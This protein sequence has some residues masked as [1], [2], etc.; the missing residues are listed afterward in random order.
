MIMVTAGAECGIG[1][2]RKSSGG[3]GE[4]NRDGDGGGGE[5][6]NNGDEDGRKSM[7]R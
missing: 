1:D 2:E 7:W 5:C 4:K 3:R 6:K